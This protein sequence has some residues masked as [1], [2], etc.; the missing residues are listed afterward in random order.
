[1][2]FL[3]LI[4]LFCFYLYYDIYMYF[5]ERFDSK[6]IDLVGYLNDQDL[7]FIRT[8][9]SN[10]SESA[11]ISNRFLLISGGILLILCSILT[12]LFS[13]GITKP[14]LNLSDISNEMSQLKLENRYTGKRKD[15]IGKLG[16]SIN[17]LADKLETTISELK[18]ANIE[19]EKDIKQ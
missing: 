19:L 3:S 5:E 15:E 9:Y 10:I 4:C 12:Y 17:T 18:S 13:C 14:I 1:M 7:I 8:S 2:R 11:V 6:Y 16:R